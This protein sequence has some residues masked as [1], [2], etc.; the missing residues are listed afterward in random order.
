[1]CVFNDDDY[2]QL[3]PLNTELSHGM[4]VKLATSVQLDHTEVDYVTMSAMQID[5]FFLQH[6]AFVKFTSTM[7]NI[8]I[9]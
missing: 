4:H 7:W 2:K 1:M 6:F 5:C 3:F 9:L 8:W